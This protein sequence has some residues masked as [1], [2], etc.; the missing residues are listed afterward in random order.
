MR[1]TALSKLQSS[2]WAFGCYFRGGDELV[3][4]IGFGDLGL[5]PWSFSGRS[6]GAADAKVMMV[7]FCCQ[8]PTQ[9]GCHCP[10]QSAGDQLVGMAQC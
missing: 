1:V 8:T 5:A 2:L 3:A 9:W 6:L 10:L 4:P 7:F